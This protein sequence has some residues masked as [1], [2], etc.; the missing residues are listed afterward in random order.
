VS[1]GLEL[2]S[3]HSLCNR[4]I[5]GAEGEMQIGCAEHGCLLASRGMVKAE[6]R[7]SFLV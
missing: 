7:I 6:P 5:T 2:R 1:A 3:T 4:P